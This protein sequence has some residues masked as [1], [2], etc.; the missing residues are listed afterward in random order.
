MRIAVCCGRAEL[1]FRATC[2]ARLCVTLARPVV[3]TSANDSPFTLRRTLLAFIAGFGATLLAHQ[4]II[5]L[6]H[7]MGIAPNAPYGMKPVPPFGVP[8]VVSLAFWGGLWGIIMIAALY[9]LRRR[10]SW[11]IAALF[12]GAFLPTLV[13]WFVA[14]PLKGQPMAAGWKPAGMAIGLIVNGGWGIGTAVLFRL[15]NRQ[16]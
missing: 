14:A 8:S 2:P 15:M 4:P 11:W 5:A 1:R 12:F 3:M 6:L 7:A 9:P 10:P 13:A 16:Q